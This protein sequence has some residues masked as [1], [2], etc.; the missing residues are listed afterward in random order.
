MQNYAICKYGS[1]FISLYWNTTKLRHV[2]HLS[3]QCL[4]QSAYPA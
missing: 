4:P 1:I 2:A 3:V